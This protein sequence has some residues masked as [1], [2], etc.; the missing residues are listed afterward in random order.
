MTLP[1]LCLPCQR[2]QGRAGMYVVEDDLDTSSSELVVTSVKQKAEKKSVR[3]NH[4]VLLSIQY[5]RI[6]YNTVILLLLLLLL[7]LHTSHDNQISSLISEQLMI[8]L[9]ITVIESRLSAQS[10]YTKL[11]QHLNTSRWR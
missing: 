4:V 5:N 2:S 1:Q 11:H 6:Q 8:T 9:Y 3:L 10:F 7:S